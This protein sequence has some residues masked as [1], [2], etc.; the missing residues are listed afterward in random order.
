MVGVCFSLGEAVRI[1]VRPPFAFRCRARMANLS[2]T[3]DLLISFRTSTP[4]QNRQ[5]DILVSNSEQQVDNF[6]G[7]LTFQ[8]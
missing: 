8:D 4:P 7:E 5:L 3:I 2:D 1:E 6:V